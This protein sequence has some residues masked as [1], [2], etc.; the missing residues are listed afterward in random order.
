M[1][2]NGV[3]PLDSRLTTEGARASSRTKLKNEFN[4]LER[5]WED[6]L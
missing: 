2:D 6:Y 3:N 5:Q 1:R 4:S